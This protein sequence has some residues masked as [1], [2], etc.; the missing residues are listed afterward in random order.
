[1]LLVCQALCV[2]AAS[3][4]EMHGA[5][6]GRGPVG[7]IERDRELAAL[8]GLLEAASGSDGGI[9]LLEGPAGIGKSALLAAVADR[10]RVAGMLVLSGRG[11]EL[12]REFGFGLVR[13]LF[14]RRLA[15]IPASR[16]RTLLSG[17]ARFAA[18]ALDLTA[19]TPQE[20]PPTPDPFAVMHGLYWLTSNLGAEQPVLVCVDDA[21][22]ADVQSLRW[23]VYV[24]RRLEGVPVALV[25]AARPR[26]AV[27][28]AAGEVLRAVRAE[29]AVD[30][31]RPEALS[32]PAVAVLA[33]SRL[34][35]QVAPAFVRACHELT[36]GN[37]FLVGELLRAIA[38]EG[39]A[40]DETSVVQLRRLAPEGVSAAVL[41]RLS[42]LPAQAR[43]V[44]LAVVVLEPHA[45]QRYVIELA[46]LDE[47]TC[48]VAVD[49]LRG[50][51]VLAAGRPLSFMHP[52]VRAAIETQLGG[53]E[54]ARLHARAARVLAGASAD[55]ELVASHLAETEPAGDVWVVEMLMSAAAQALV[56]G[57]PPSAAAHLRRALDEPPDPRRRGDVLLVLGRAAFAAQQPDCIE[58]LREAVALGE[59]ASERASAALQLGLAYLA[60]GRAAGVRD[61]V[62]AA[63][64]IESRNRELELALDALELMGQS[65][66][67]VKNEFGER[68]ERLGRELPGATAA[69]RTLLSRIAMT[70]AMFGHPV[71]E[72]LEIIPRALAGGALE[73]EELE[74]ELAFAFGAP[75]PGLVLAICD[76]LKRSEELF[77][78]Y[79]ERTLQAGLL[80]TFGLAAATRAIPAFRRGDLALAETSASDALQASDAMAFGFW[81]PIALGMLVR[82]LLEQGAPELAV[83]ALERTPPPP[84]LH[85]AWQMSFV[86]HGRG[87]L[88]LAGRRPEMALAELQRAGEVLLATGFV[89]PSVVEW[90]ADAARAHLALGNPARARELARE[91]LELARAFG[92]PRAIGVALRACAAAEEERRLEHLQTAVEVLRGSESRLEFAYALA[93]LGAALRRDDQRSAARERLLEAL[94]LA[95][96]CRSARLQD[97]VRDE[98]SALG[99]RAPRSAVSG[100]DALT[101]SE[102]RVARMA[103]EG[104]SNKEIAQALF[105]TYKTVDTHLYRAYNKLGISSRRQLRDALGWSSDSAT[106]S[107]R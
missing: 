41:L 34:G 32:E 68:L 60:A 82:V 59:V 97:L 89:N 80:P 62:A 13:Q 11:G 19:A 51:E 21:H 105:V 46:G 63:R 27:G 45:E 55:A 29:S 101:A 93:D 18:P 25:I 67:G 17:A 20:L 14:E 100:H 48:A 54:R 1:M 96:T 57:A 9:L 72:V 38:A 35:A 33:R 8:D 61:A 42:R 79:I 84:Q 87:L 43:A 104:M 64:R 3:G 70:K 76:E 107:T 5:V 95:Q 98:L 102:A 86:H 74:L 88:A 12:E 92:A 47:A 37:P 52:L 10:A 75:R 31:L 15:T 6:G 26:E 28:D 83:E 90:R 71:A 73:T 30:V 23:L 66:G 85:A 49:A 77:G 69:E 99:T 40:A 103:A 22:W 81:L 4:F 39:L 36:A 58:Y 16:R 24:A 2:V 53:A 91:E 50:A 78:D 7:L 106:R 65:A 94:E 44:A 56:R